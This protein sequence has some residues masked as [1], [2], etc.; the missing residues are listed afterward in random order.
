ME[1]EDNKWVIKL[2]ICVLFLAILILPPLMYSP[3]PVE[4]VKTI[5]NTSIEES[6]RKSAAYRDSLV[7]DAK[8]KLNQLQLN[9]L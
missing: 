2:S 8:I 6:L 4:A 9:N 3:K 1:K 5:D 7:N